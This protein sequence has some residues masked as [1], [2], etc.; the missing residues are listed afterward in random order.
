M[1]GTDI[2]TNSRRTFLLG[3][4]TGFVTDGVPDRR[5]VDFYGARSS[6]QLSCAI[7]GNV[8]I[9]SGHA[10]NAVT[11]RISNDPIWRTLAAAVTVRGTSPGIQLATAWED[12][13]GAI[14]FRPKSWSET[15]ARS[16]EIAAT[17]TSSRLQKLFNDLREGTELAAEAG[18]RHVQLHAAH[19]YLFSLL[20]DDRIYDGASD[21]LA[22]VARWAEESRAAGLETSL[23]ISLRTG[24][25]LFDQDGTERFQDRAS[26]S[27]V[28]LIDLSSGFYNIDKRL[29]Y[30][31][32]AATLAQRWCE[33]AAVAARHPSRNFILSG[34]AS[35][36]VMT[37]PD[38]VH[39][40]LCRDL[41]A[42]PNFLDDPARGCANS[43]KCHYYSRGAAHVT[44][45]QWGD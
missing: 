22:L 24:D 4:N 12:Y 32:I 40:G 41:I 19:G 36:S 28:E 43:G 13:A 34:R 10:S 21:S 35:A 3:L 44:C 31:S 26:A 1:S 30:P 27:P 33:S 18:F 15:I 29:I 42:N 45:P 37:L 38:N 16:R 25:T 8:V 11:P 23:R 14:S 6:P 20:V 5:M 9:P 39:L 2:S 7:V 17:V